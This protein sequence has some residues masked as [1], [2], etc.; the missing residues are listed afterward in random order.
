MLSHKIPRA[1]ILADNRFPS[2]F[3]SAAAATQLKPTT[4][5]SFANSLTFLLVY[6][7]QGEAT[8]RPTLP[9]LQKLA[10]TPFKRAQTGLFHGALIQFGNNVPFS[11]QKT[12]R[13]WLPNIQNKGL[14]SDLLGR[15]TNVKLTTRALRTIKK[16]RHKS[17]EFAPLILLLRSPAWEERKRAE[18]LL[19][20]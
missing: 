16:V 2:I 18:W 15:E 5:T 1:S 14:Y 11:K 8:M 7:Q 3:S 4:V 17:S 20:L 9:S 12:R 19:I 6:D 10:S 13:T